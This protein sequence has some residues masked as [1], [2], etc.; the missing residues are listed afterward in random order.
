M[1]RITYKPIGSDDPQTTRVGNYSFE[2][3]KAVEVKAP[4][5]K[6]DDAEGA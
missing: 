4:V 6:S 5:R 1:P 3:G 2:A